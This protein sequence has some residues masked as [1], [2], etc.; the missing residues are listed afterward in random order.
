MEAW[1]QLVAPVPLPRE[2]DTRVLEY[3]QSDLR[4]RLAPEMQREVDRIASTA[5]VSAGGL[6]TRRALAE[7]LLPAVKQMTGGFLLALSH[8]DHNTLTALERRMS[9]RASKDPLPPE[10]ERQYEVLT[11]GWGLP[12]MIA[13]ILLPRWAFSIDWHAVNARYFNSMSATGDTLPVRSLPRDGQAAA[14][15]RDY[16]TQNAWIGVGWSLL[17]TAASVA[18]LAPLGIVA[19]RIGEAITI[20]VQHLCMCLHI[21]AIYHRGIDEHG[22]MLRL[23]TGLFGFSVGGEILTILAEQMALWGLQHSFPGVAFEA[24]AKGTQGWIIK[25]LAPRFVQDTAAA[26]LRLTWAGLAAASGGV[27]LSAI[28]NA[29]ATKVVAGRAM[30]LNRSWLQQALQRA[31]YVLSLEGVRECVL[32]GDIAMAH[33][34]GAISEEEVQ[35]FSTLLGRDYRSGDDGAGTV[36]VERR[37][38]A[39]IADLAGLGHPSRERL[40]SAV[41][42]LDREHLTA[43]ERLVVGAQW[44]AMAVVDGMAPSEMALERAGSGLLFEGNQQLDWK[45]KVVKRS[46]ELILSPS[47]QERMGKSPSGEVLADAIAGLGGVSVHSYLLD[48]RALA[49]PGPELPFSRWEAGRILRARRALRGAVF[50]R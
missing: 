9:W 36:I 5:E 10:V 46:I 11:E 7:Q 43:F 33:A 45:Y 49:E 17:P 6:S 21:G 20:Y 32:Q 24:L 23:V 19:S 50:S 4:H 39:Y 41:A 18:G 31:P 40:E 38:P 25:Q 44:F 8:T 1:G 12:A 29:V 3:L 26:G 2:T 34:D 35:L 14:V 15:M 27:L 37:W 47:A 42:C 22:S 48:D 28:F 13:R 16:V 30:Y